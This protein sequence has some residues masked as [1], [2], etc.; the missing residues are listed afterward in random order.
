MRDV[1]VLW[2]LCSIGTYTLP[3]LTDEQGR[4]RSTNAGERCVDLS[5]FTPHQRAVSFPGRQL[6]F[7][8]PF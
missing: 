8:F 6:L 3:I 2:V 5:D 7:S 1:Y 4:L